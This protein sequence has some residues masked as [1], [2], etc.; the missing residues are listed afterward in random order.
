LAVLYSICGVGKSSL[1]HVDHASA[2][3]TPAISQDFQ[4]AFIGPDDPFIVYYGRWPID[5]AFFR[6]MGSRNKLI[7]LNISDFELP[8]SISA[9]TPQAA[10]YQKQRIKML[11]DQ[12]A[13]VFAYLSIGEE[14][15]EANNNEGYAGDEL[16]P[17]RCHD[18]AKCCAR[19]FASYYIDD[20]TGR[21]AKHGEPN[22]FMA[23]Y[24]NAGNPCWR[25]RMKNEA[26]NILS[27]GVTGLFLDT[28]DTAT[29]EK[30]KWTQGG[31]IEL[32]KDLNTVT[33]NIIIN[34]GILMLDGE[35][36]NDYKQLSW[37]IMFENFYTE[38]ENDKGVK[39]VYWESN[40]TYASKLKKKN[41]LIVDFA[42][43]KQ[44]E[45]NDAI[46][47]AQKKEVASVNADFNT[48]WP[49]YIA[50]PNFTEIRYDSRCVLKR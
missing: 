17:C 45:N 2:R 32:L 10:N 44:F 16:G 34:R 47:K 1:H 15:V 4:L 11:R 8:T 28:L 41:V 22:N 18:P 13:M 36:A 7:I 46:V 48:R 20:G 5:D 19:G 40:K 6:T 39:S 35:Y 14:N 37:A 27:L 21:P 24:V 31:M 33:R 3:S 43:C 29:E 23:A 38:W 25:S 9:G 49:N 30:Y 12:G 50:E 26:R 42:N